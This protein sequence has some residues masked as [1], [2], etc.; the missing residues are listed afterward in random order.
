M[1]AC[2]CTFKL[3]ASVIFNCTKEDTAVERNKPNFPTHYDYLTLF[4]NYSLIQ[5]EKKK[6]GTTGINTRKYGQNSS[7]LSIWK[8]HKERSELRVFNEL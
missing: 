2:V 1:R 6:H 3:T 4:W 5:Q 7:S 8:T